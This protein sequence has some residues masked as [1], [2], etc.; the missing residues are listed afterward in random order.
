VLD[1]EDEMGGSVADEVDA[2]VVPGGEV[3]AAAQLLVEVG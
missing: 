1:G 3:L 2:G